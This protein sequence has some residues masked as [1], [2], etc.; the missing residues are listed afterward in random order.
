MIQCESVKVAIDA[1]T[2]QDEAHELV[3]VHLRGHLGSRSGDRD[4]AGSRL[5]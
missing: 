4:A 3:M 5:L 1:Q 2:D